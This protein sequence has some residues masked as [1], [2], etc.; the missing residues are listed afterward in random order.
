MQ[1][2]GAGGGGGSGANEAR[3]EGEEA[4]MLQPGAGVGGVMFPTLPHLHP[5]AGHSTHGS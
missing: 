5:P 2:P 3:Q 4:A 1:Q